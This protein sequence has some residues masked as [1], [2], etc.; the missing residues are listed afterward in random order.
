H[1]QEHGDLDGADDKRLG[2]VKPGGVT[3]NQRLEHVPVQEQDR[4]ALE[5]LPHPLLPPNAGWHFNKQVAQG[6]V[7][8]QA[9]RRQE[10]AQ[11]RKE[12]QGQEKTSKTKA[13]NQ[14]PGKGIESSIALIDRVAG[15][16]GTANVFLPAN[17][18]A[19]DQRQAPSKGKR[20]VPRERP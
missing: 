13:A 10:P 20:Q 17:L 18:R 14:P 7:T 6:P 11:G 5:E 4:P 12:N 2:P 3:D 1:R 9:Q 15:E 8:A 16:P 19:F